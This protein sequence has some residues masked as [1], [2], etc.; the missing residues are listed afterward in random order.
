MTSRRF[1]DLKT[2]V[3]KGAR[4]MIRKYGRFF[5]PIVERVRDSLAPADRETFNDRLS[6]AY[7]FV[8]TPKPGCR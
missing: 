7:G 2:A 6:M 4:A 8:W 3:L 5:N 1:G